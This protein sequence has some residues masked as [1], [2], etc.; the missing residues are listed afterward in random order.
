[1]E[2]RLQ[3]FMSR[4]G[5]ASRRKS[6][7]L[8]EAGRVTVNNKTAT[9]GM[10]VTERDEVHVDGELIRLPSRHATYMLNKPRG[11]VTTK[12]D[13]YGRTTVMELLPDIPGL[14]PVGRLDKDSE[15]LL[16]FTTD[17]ELTMLLTHPRYGHEKT[18]RVWCKEGTVDP[19]ALAVL[20]QGIK[21]EDGIARAVVAKT[22]K[23]GCIITL[24]EGKNKQVRRMLAA[25]GYRVKRLL[26]TKFA[27]LE[28]GD[29][30]EGKYRKLS[31]ADFV[32]LGYTDPSGRR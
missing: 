6:E 31:P 14:H 8:I 2:E 27:G 4:A 30:P 7:E 10:K 9:I 28:L 12:S 20:E 19:S 26:R 24:N 5:I 32:K 29:L 18:Y 23:D 17:G 1:M 25:S 15:G 21:L 16:L 22:A 11:I 3:K 13:E